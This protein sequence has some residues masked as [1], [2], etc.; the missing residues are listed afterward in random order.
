MQNLSVRSGREVFFG[1]E[2]LMSDV[3]NILDA[4]GVKRA[5]TRISHEIIES[6]KGVK[7]LALAGIRT[8]GVVLAELIAEKIREIESARI[9]VG[10]IDITLYRDDLSVG[11]H[12]PTLRSTEIDFSIDDR[13]IVLV[14]DV[15]YTGR[16]IRAGISALMDFGRPRMIKLAVLVDRGH[17]ELPIRADFVGK[18]IP[19]SKD[20]VIKVRFEGD[21][22]VDIE[23]SPK[24]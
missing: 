10:V 20:D 4:D 1:I 12:H 24:K 6:N 18:N 16:T 2:A 17:R 15:L 7:N 13:V 11:T 21:I 9:P 3:R 22:S 19:T 23:L 8:G 14:D 5:I